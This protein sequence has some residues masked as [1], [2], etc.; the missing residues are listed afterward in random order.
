MDPD[1][2]SSQNRKYRQKNIEDASVIR[3]GPTPKR[4]AAADDR[5]HARLPASVAEVPREPWPAPES[6]RSRALVAHAGLAIRQPPCCFTRDIVANRQ[7]KLSN[8]SSHVQETMLYAVT[9]QEFTWFCQIAHQLF[10][11][12]VTNHAESLRNWQVS[13]QAVKI[14]N[15]QIQMPAGSNAILFLTCRQVSAFYFLIM[16]M[17]TNYMG[18]FY[19]IFSYVTCLVQVLWNQNCADV[20]NMSDWLWPIYIM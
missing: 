16:W 13:C 7:L 1:L 8:S 2:P 14:R 18:T 9:V 4:R 19:I 17:R 11:R 3:W 15:P 12:T 5:Q 20:T 6:D 10:N